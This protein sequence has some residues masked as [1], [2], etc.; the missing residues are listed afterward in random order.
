MFPQNEHLAASPLNVHWNVVYLFCER[1][2]F[3]AIKYLFLCLCAHQAH[4]QILGNDLNWNLVASQADSMKVCSYEWFECFFSF[5]FFFETTERKTNH[6]AINISIDSAYA[7]INPGWILNQNICYE[8]SIALSNCTIHFWTETFRLKYWLRLLSSICDC[9][10]LML[11]NDYGLFS[12]LRLNYLF[13][14]KIWH[15]R[16]IFENYFF[17]WILCIFCA[18]FVN[19]I[20]S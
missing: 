8:L 11:S 18:L 1:Q 4:Y 20:L 7:L 3:E 17:F 5:F 12:A 16:C 14:K 15:R 10:I 13:R 19:E 2:A 6:N 9:I